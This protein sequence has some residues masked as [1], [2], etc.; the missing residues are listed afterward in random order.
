MRVS[1]LIFLDQWN[2]KFRRRTQQPFFIHGCCCS[3]KIGQTACG[4]GYQKTPRPTLNWQCKHLKG[5]F[6]RSKFRGHIPHQEIWV[7]LGGENYFCFLHGC[8]SSGMG[9]PAPRQNKCSSVS[10]PNFSTTLAPLDWHRELNA[11]AEWVRKGSPRSQC[12][13]TNWLTFTSGTGASDL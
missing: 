2:L 3:G 1:F 9:R 10:D 6:S 8:S 5:N 11:K 13:H 4:Y 7:S 12:K